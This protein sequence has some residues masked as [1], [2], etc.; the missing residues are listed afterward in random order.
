M[1]NSAREL[2]ENSNSAQNPLEELMKSI[3]I[4][5]FSTFGIKLSRQY[6]DSIG[7]RVIILGIISILPI[8]LAA[9]VLIKIY[10]HY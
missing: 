6:R 9:Y 8:A 7:I 10:L 5:V 1:P 3:I 2:N 4:K